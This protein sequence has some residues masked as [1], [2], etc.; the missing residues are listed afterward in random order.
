MVGGRLNPLHPRMR[1]GCRLQKVCPHEVMNS[2]P[3][4]SQFVVGYGGCEAGEAG[5]PTLTGCH[6]IML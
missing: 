4:A 2:Q 6:P 1:R 5:S 3:T